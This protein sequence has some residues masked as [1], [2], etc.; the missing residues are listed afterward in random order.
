MRW[1]RASAIGAG[2]AGALLA[3]AQANREAAEAATVEHGSLRLTVA[4]D[5]ARYAPGEEIT[6]TL[7]VVNV[8]DAPVALEFQSAQRFDVSVADRAGSEIWRWSAGR[9]FAQM[10]GSEAVAAGETVAYSAAYRGDLAP[11]SYLAVGRLTA[12]N[13]PLRAAT[14]FAVEQP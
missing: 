1:T 10:L 3:C 12:R 14:L 4:T 5:R 11:G 13:H 6:I 9:G 8:G 2:V 7:H